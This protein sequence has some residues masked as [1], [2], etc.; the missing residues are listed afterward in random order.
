MKPTIIDL[1]K[2][3]TITVITTLLFT[4]A[5]FAGGLTADTSALDNVLQFVLQWVVRV[6]IIIAILGG[7][8]FAIAF[9]SDN[10]EN[11]TRGLKIIVAGFMLAALAK[12][13][14]IF[15]F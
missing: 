8:D 10:P 14:E 12:A 6:G 7:I 4:T 5:V 13:P 11:K 3:I 1:K 9:M 2:T 15:G